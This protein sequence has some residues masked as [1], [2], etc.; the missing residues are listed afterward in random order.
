MWSKIKKWIGLLLFVVP[1]ILLLT[2]TNY[3]ADPSNTFHNFSEE[4][5]QAMLAGHTVQ[6]LS[7]NL[8]E[9][10]VLQHLIED[11][12]AQVGTIVCG[13]SIV[14][15]IDSE[16]AGTESFYNFAV[17]SADYYDLLATMAMMKLNG[18]KADRV[19]LALDTRLF[20]TKVYMSDGRH[21]RLMDYSEY[22]IDYLN[23]EVGEG[24]Q[25]ELEVRDS[26]LSKVGQLFSISYF[27][28]SVDYVK[29]NGI[30]ALNNERWK[31]VEEDFNGNKY[32][33]DYS[34]VYARE[35]EEITAEE[36]IA[37]CNTYWME[38]NVTEYTLAN[39]ENMQVFEKMIG[40]LQAQGTE[41][42][43]FLCPFAPAL[44][45]RVWEEQYPILF[46]LEEYAD[47]LAEKY[48]VEVQGS[49]NPYAVG[50]TNED[51]YDARH[52]K[53]SSLKRVFTF[54]D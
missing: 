45:D 53:K 37:S 51:F 6:V 8:D 2:G 3:L 50:M 10:E 22:M 14:L 40:Y 34:I 47:T 13:A 42:E 16:M 54:S 30:A 28:H 48:G 32:L 43:L 19:I 29:K 20:D 52:I 17:S 21:D 5:S 35:M 1:L 26:F 9:R 27:Q 18:K 12:P 25:P 24:F 31:I 36:V 33:P 4:M 7:N 23:G 46:Q 44:W 11:M 15:S 38:A 49:Y 39:E 41:V